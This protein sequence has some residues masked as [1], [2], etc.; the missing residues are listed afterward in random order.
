LKKNLPSG[1]IHPENR[2]T[3][4]EKYIL[5]A[6]SHTPLTDEKSIVQPLRKHQWHV[7]QGISL[8][9]ANFNLPNIMPCHVKLPYLEEDCFTPTGFAKTNPLVKDEVKLVALKEFCG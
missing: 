7:G 1:K 9:E 4:Q 8:S 2:I 3:P 5:S 6:S